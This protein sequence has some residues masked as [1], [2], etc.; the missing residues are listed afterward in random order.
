MPEAVTSAIAA[1]YPKAT[2]TLLER[3]TEGEKI[4]YEIAMKG[5]PVKSVQLM[6]EGTWISPK[7]AK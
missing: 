1:R 6:P 3:V 5:A 7:P 4:S 2:P